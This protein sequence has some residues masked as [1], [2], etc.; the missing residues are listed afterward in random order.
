M[1]LLQLYLFL[2]ILP[3]I[4]NA[5]V[6]FVIIGILGLVS[7]LTVYGFAIIDEEENQEK[8]KSLLRGIKIFGSILII[9]LIISSITPTDK[10]IYMVAG[11][12]AATNDK[13]LKKLPDNVLKAANSYLESLQKDLDKKSNNPTK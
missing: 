3:N 12:Y 10:Q 13:E 6:T 9:S 5:V 2:V 7:C 11:G 1:D 4:G 8:R